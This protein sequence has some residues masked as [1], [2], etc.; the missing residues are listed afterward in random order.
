MSAQTPQS[1][2]NDQERRMTLEEEIYQES[3]EVLSQM[4]DEE[5]S[6]RETL[7]TPPASPNVITTGSHKRVLF[8]ED[9]PPPLFMT[10][11]SIEFSDDF[12]RDN[13]ATVNHIYS[14][15]SNQ[16]DADED[17]CVPLE[18]LPEYK[19]YICVR[20]VR[21]KRRYWIH[22]PLV[23]LCCLVV[24]MKLMTTSVDRRSNNEID[25]VRKELADGKSIIRKTTLPTADDSISSTVVSETIT[26]TRITP[27]HP[28]NV[29]LPTADDSSSNTVVSETR[30]A[31][32]ITPPTNVTINTSPKVVV[33]KNETNSAKSLKET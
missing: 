32:R 10:P 21:K 23:I 9:R 14:V 5:A 2:N 19:A 13:Q 3:L 31:T 26:A 25:V 27:P 11:T 18:N 24:L 30:T 15:V 6:V 28:T 33:A 7:Q 20:K 8:P 22:M 16:D 4:D 1:N 17:Y 12:Y 29:K